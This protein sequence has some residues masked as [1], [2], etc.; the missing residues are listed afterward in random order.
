M[1][2][3]FEVRKWRCKSKKGTCLLLPNPTANI[4]CWKALLWL[5]CLWFS[6]ANWSLL[7]KNFAWCQPLALLFPNVSFWE[8]LCATRNSGKVVYSKA[9]FVSLITWS[10]FC[11]TLFLSESSFPCTSSQKWKIKMQRDEIFWM[12]LSNKILSARANRSHC[13]QINC[14]NGIT[15]FVKVES[16]FWF[17]LLKLQV[18]AKQC[19]DNLGMYSV[20]IRRKDWTKWKSC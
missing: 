6:W 5:C 8:I 14:W 17:A 9:M 10:Q 16:F 12:K 7:W 11:S 19:N 18:D 15:H 20:Q 4:N 13:V 2:L 3:L 1:Q